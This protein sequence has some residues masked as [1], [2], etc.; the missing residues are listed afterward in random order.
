MNQRHI[1]T[2]FIED[3]PVNLPAEML[4]KLFV[5]IKYNVEKVEHVVNNGINT[6]S[7]FVYLT[8][9]DEA[10]RFEREMSKN[11]IYGKIC[12]MKLLEP[13]NAKVE[14]EGLIDFM[15]NNKNLTDSIITDVIGSQNAHMQASNSQV[16]VWQKE[17][18]NKLGAMA[19]KN[20]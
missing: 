7:C 16:T 20:P 8:T 10:L 3:M 14:D 9:H 5:M 4:K 6:G 1:K 13:C 2:V 17:L 12:K 11:K 19:A 15:K 18:N